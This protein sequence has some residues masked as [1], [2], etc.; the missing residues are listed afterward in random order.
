MAVALL[1]YD[2]CWYM[3][4]ALL[5]ASVVYK[6]RGFVTKLAQFQ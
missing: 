5:A 6:K 4:P 1:S 3:D 2:L